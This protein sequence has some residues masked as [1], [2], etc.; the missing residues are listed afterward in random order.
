[1]L[2]NWFFYGSIA[3]SHLQT[4]ASSSSANEPRARAWIF[5][6]QFDVAEHTRFANSDTDQIFPEYIRELIDSRV[7]YLNSN[8]KGMDFISY[9]VPRTLSSVQS[10]GVVAMDGIFH[11]S[12]AVAEDTVQGLFG[13][14]EGLTT[15]WGALYL[16]QAKRGHH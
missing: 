3:P 13:S 11:G 16:A 5:N 10:R 14:V 8:L 7:S 2:Y 1:M 12:H 9:S 6:A 4:R 15:S